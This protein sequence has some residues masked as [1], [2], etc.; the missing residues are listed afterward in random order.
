VPET[1]SIDSAQPFSLGG[2]GVGPNNDQFHG[3][4]DDVW[5]HIG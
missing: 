4:L 1:L 3:A 2:K 5:I